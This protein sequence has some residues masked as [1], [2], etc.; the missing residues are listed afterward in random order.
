MIMIFSND[1]DRTTIEVMWY[2]TSMNKD[3][4]H[5]HENEVFEIKIN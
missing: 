3:F 1:N 2:L 4:T 5:I